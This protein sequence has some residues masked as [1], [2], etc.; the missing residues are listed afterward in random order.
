M[1]TWTWRYISFDGKV[2]HNPIYIRMDA[3]DQLLL[4]EG[5]CSQ[6]GMVEYH[7]D[8]WPGTKMNIEAIKAHELKVKDASQLSVK[9]IRTYVSR[10]NHSC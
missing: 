7:K 9:Q 6:L 4:A 10:G 8:V 2:L 5:V 3:Q 1:D